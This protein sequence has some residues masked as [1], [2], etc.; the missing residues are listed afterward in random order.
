MTLL[1]SSPPV[2]L[3]I[4]SP[5]IALVDRTENNSPLVLPLDLVLFSHKPMKR[6][7]TQIHKATLPATSYHSR[8]SKELSDNQSPLHKLPRYTINYQI[9][10][11]LMLLFF[12]SIKSNRCF[13]SSAVVF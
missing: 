12:P 4:S 8:T 9:L 5:L 1:Q 2:R 10:H 3:R 7:C 11:Y 6:S 13:L